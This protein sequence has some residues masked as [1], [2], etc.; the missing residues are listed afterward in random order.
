VFTLRADRR[1]HWTCRPSTT[2]KPRPTRTAVEHLDHQ[3]ARR[4]GQTLSF[5]IRAEREGRFTIPSFDVATSDGTVTVRPLTIDVGAATLPGGKNGSAAKVSDVVDARLTPSTMTPYAG[6]VFEVGVIVGMTGGRHGE[7]VG[8]PT[9]NKSGVVAE[10]WSDGQVV[11]TDRGSGVRFHTRA[12]APQAGRVQVAPIQ[13]EVAIESGR[14]RID[15]FGDIDDAFA[16]MRK[17]G[18]A[19]LFNSFFS[20]GQKTSATVRSNSLQLDV[21]PL[22]QPAPE[23]FSGAVGQFEL[24]ST[25]APAQLKTGEPVTWTL[26]LSGTGNWPGGVVLPA[27]A[28]PN[29]VRTLQPKQHKEFADGQEFAGQVSEDLVLVPNK[30]GDYHLSPVRFVY[31]DPAKGKYQTLEAQPPMLHITGAPISAPQPQ[32]AAAAPA[33]P[34]P[35]AAAAHADAQAN[36]PIAGAAQLL[37][38]D[39]KS[40]HAIGFA[41]LGATAFMLIVAAPFVLILLDWT[42]L[43]IAAR[44]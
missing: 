12:V 7:V 42:G 29:D 26:T 35:G 21:Q 1:R 27:R 30:P 38:R 23:G 14:E 8:T 15:P 24:K 3:R 5:P 44:G 9:W 2:W 32:T 31:F 37:P 41:P 16:D 19:N 13:Q 4:V 20:R 10:A 33:A 39:A 6:E 18:G 25:L 22:P 34:A 11:S 36:A 28:V 40:G 17:F 43:A